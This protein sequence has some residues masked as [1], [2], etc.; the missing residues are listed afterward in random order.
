MSAVDKP[1]VPIYI[2]EA[3]A[4]VKLGGVEVKS[5]ENAVSRFSL[6][7]WGLAG[8]GKTTLACTAPGDILLIN[9]DPEGH[10]VI[11]GKP[12][13]H[14][15]DFS[16]QPD[17]YVIKFKEQ[18]PLGLS[19]YLRENPNIKTVVVDSLTSFAQSALDHGVVDASGTR[20]HAGS[21][22]FEDPGFGGYGRKLRWTLALVQ[23][24]LRVTG[25]FGRNVI[26]IAHEDMPTKDKKG[27]ITGITLMLGSSLTGE[28]PYKLSEIW[29]M[30]DTG[31]ARRLLVRPG[32][33]RAPMKSRMFH[34]DKNI[35]CV[36]KPDHET[37]LADWF[38]Q[39]Q[40]NGFRKIELPSSVG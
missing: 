35:E 1:V 10:V 19:R 34:A 29:H 13:V 14:V 2:K 28:I 5:S 15:L 21:V 25:A 38:D 31:K 30:M 20:Q 9:F 23:R 33:M 37:T 27:E 4:P 18:D 40:A 39:W 32:R 22:T 6:L 16:Q 17:D 7:L 36:I 26:F 11:A 12:G 3:I 24:L 8:A